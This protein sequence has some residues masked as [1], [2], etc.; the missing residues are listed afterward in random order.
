MPSKKFQKQRMAICGDEME[1]IETEDWV[2][3]IGGDMGCPECG[4]ELVHDEHKVFDRCLNCGW[5]KKRK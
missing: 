1:R 4:T 2:E 5:Y 3:D